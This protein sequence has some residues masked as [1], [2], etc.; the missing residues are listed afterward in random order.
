MALRPDCLKLVTR[1]AN[2]LSCALTELVGTAAPIVAIGAL[3]L[4]T[5]A[6][7]NPALA[8]TSL[9]TFSSTDTFTA[10]SPASASTATYNSV[11]PQ[12][13][14]QPFD[15]GLGTLSSTGIIW[16]TVVSFTGTIGT[17][18]VGGNVSIGLSGQY[19]INSNSYAGAGGGGR[20]SAASGTTFSANSSPSPIT[21]NT[22]FSNPASGY[23]PAILAVFLGST[24]YTI[25]YASL[26][27]PFT[28]YT[29]YYSNIESGSAAFTTTA[30][31][32]YNYVAAPSVAGAPGPLPLL[33]AGAAWGWSRQL[34]R[35]CAQRQG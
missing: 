2:G 19:Y 7:S 5:V 32:T 24:P 15:S 14:V 25:T 23:N 1:P 31:V 12:F 16:N 13:T 21:K 34:R 22:Q 6:Q 18:G 20:N 35:R 29:F 10:F 9:Q 3:G 8:A 17:A 28:P 27:S 26:D 11:L 33:G 4:L 30:S